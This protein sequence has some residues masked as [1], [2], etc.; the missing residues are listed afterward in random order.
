MPESPAPKHEPPRK[1]EAAPDPA[2]PPSGDEGIRFTGLSDLG[3]GWE[4]YVEN[5]QS[6]QTAC[7]KAGEKINGARIAGGDLARSL[8]V[9]EY[10]ND[11][12]VVEIGSRLA[13]RQVI[14]RESEPELY[15]RFH[16]GGAKKEEVK[17]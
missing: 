9:L 10:G 5:L 12:F 4:V 15:K 8:V 6:N 2:P 11:L 13:R 17:H 14:S 3:S 16:E 1:Q 7:L